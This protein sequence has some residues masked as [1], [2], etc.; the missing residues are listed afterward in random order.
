MSSMAFA[1]YSRSTSEAQAASAV[2]AAIPSPS[3]SRRRTPAPHL[4]LERGRIK[5]APVRVMGE[6]ES[7]RGDR[8]G[9]VFRLRKALL[10]ITVV[11][12]MLHGPQFT[13][14]Y[15]VTGPGRIGVLRVLRAQQIGKILQAD[16]LARI[17]VTRR[18]GEVVGTSAI[19]EYLPA[20]LV[21]FFFLRMRD[22]HVDRDAAGLFRDPCDKGFHHRALVRAIAEMVLGCFLLGD[23]LQAAHAVNEPLL[24]VH[25][26]ARV[27]EILRK[28]RVGA[29]DDAG[30][31]TQVATFERCVLGTAL[32]LPQI[33]AARLPQLRRIALLKRFAILRDLVGRGTL[34]HR[35]AGERQ[36]EQRQ[37]E[38]HL[39][40]CDY[41]MTAISVRLS[42]CVVVSAARSRSLNVLRSLTLA[43]HTTAT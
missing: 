7:Q 34:P 22:R 2:S 37:A 42:L 5:A 43:S 33:F 9:G 23:A 31:L 29:F 8:V 25:H 11:E 20:Q 15:P 4:A 36:E 32:L 35:D 41:A 10:A 1:R 30:A 26:F 28:M 19:E 17:A 38:A 27:G 16:A 39:H 3:H 6:K 18:A 12:P 40:H 24:D 21:G 14:R 13:L